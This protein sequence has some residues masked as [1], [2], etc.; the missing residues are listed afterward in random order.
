MLIRLI[1]R[2]PIIAAIRAIDDVVQLTPGAGKELVKE[3]VGLP[4][5]EAEAIANRLAMQ[6]MGDID[7]KIK[8]RA[9]AKTT[10]TE[11]EKHRGRVTSMGEM[12]AIRLGEPIRTVQAG[13]PRGEILSGV[14]LFN[15]GM[16]RQADRAE[17][18]IVKKRRFGETRVLGEAKALAIER[19]G[20]ALAAR[21][22]LSQERFAEERALTRFTQGSPVSAEGAASLA[23]GVSAGLELPEAIQRVID[24]MGGLGVVLGKIALQSGQ[25]LNLNQAGST[26]ADP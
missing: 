20:E 5:G 14:D 9:D 16:S 10:L 19:F 18:D 12:G 3:Q 24:S 11:E 4:L 23:N 6:S 22:S 13:R 26:S 1:K 17:S 7:K 21:E 15:A 2:H 25:Q 8:E